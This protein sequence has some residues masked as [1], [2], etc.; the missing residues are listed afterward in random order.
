VVGSRDS[1][2]GGLLEKC[3]DSVEEDM[4]Q[5]LRIPT[6]FNEEVQTEIGDEMYQLRAELNQA[7]STIRILKDKVEECPDFS[8]EFRG[9]RMI[10]YG[11][12]LDCQIP[13]F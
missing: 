1:T 9:H 4:L 13:R 10:S 8:Q 2:E 3:G 6:S 5:E 12:T 7:Y 11:T